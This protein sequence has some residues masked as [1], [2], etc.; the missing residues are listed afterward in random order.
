RH[1]DPTPPFP[2][3]GPNAVNGRTDAAVI[4]RHCPSAVRHRTCGVRPPVPTLGMTTLDGTLL[5]PRRCQLEVGNGPAVVVDRIP[6]G[7]RFGRPAAG[8]GGASVATSV[9]ANGVASPA[10]AG[11]SSGRVIGQAGCTPDRQTHRG[12]L[13][14]HRENARLRQPLGHDDG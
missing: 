13:A 14:T 4:A 7:G 8:D 6:G 1:P 10:G 11:R 3:N 5:A 12:D 2:S 9:L